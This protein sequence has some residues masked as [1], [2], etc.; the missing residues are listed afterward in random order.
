MIRKTD[1]LSEFHMIDLCR[2]IFAVVVVSAH[3]KL[4]VNINNAF[5]EAVVNYLR[6]VA[7]MFFYVSVGFFAIYKM[8]QPYDKNS[9]RLN[10]QIKKYIKLYVVWTLISLPATIYG[11]SISGEGFL[12]C[13][14]SYIKYFLFVGK[15]YNAYH[16]YFL[17][18]CVVALWFMKAMLARGCNIGMYLAA[19][20]TVYVMNGCIMSLTNSSSDILK[21]IGAAYKYIF[22]EGSV[23]TGMAYIATGALIA[24][25]KVYLNKWC[26]L[27]LLIV[28]AVFKEAGWLHILK[29]MV[30]FMLMLDIRL[31]ETTLWKKLRDISAIVYYSH[32]VV[33][34]IYTIAIIHM[35]DK[36]GMDSFFVTISACCL[37]AMLL[38]N[39]KDKSA[40]IRKVFF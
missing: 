27:L 28:I 40:W 39:L 8:P 34:S 12:H 16:L 10:N 11:Y 15:L 14:F 5:V 25:S 17:L 24:E 13:I 2:F 36:P 22:N 3:T 21:S 18:A 6:G 19:G 20:Y 23:F 4:F 7:V 32:L 30:L 26:S 9:D 29:P 35:P 1:G 31:P 37:L 33:Y 38:L